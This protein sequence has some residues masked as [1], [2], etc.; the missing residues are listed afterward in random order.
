MSWPDP[1]ALRWSPTLR[2]PADDGTQLAV[3][4][5]GDNHPGP[6]VVFAHGWTFSSRQWHYQR[7]LA[8]RWRVV[9]FD[10]RGHGESE[11]GPRE[12]RT[13]DQVG[14]D[15]YSVMQATSAGRPVVPVGFSMGGMAVMAMA[16]QYP[17]AI[18]SWVKAAAFVSTSPGGQPENDYRLPAPLARIW[19]TRFAAG[20][21]QMRDDPVAAERVRRTGSRFSLAV[22]RWLNFGPKAERRLVAFTEAMS[23][24]CGAEVVGDFA[25][26][27]EAHDKLEALKA[28]AGIPTLVIVGSH[29]RLL[30]PSHSRALA[31]AIPDS[32]L[33][34]LKGAGHCTMLEQPDAVNAALSELLLSVADERVQAEAVPAPSSPA[35]SS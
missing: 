12:H 31:A 5:L 14:R 11:P 4:I 25:T 26:S 19:R 28:L 10:H 34:E 13:V 24:A 20:L 2:V 15:L 16:G 6:T 23:G 7:L 30:P 29:D 17:E 18:G 8:E 27:L 33:L 1:K 3:E 21:A 22:S 35:L 32:R 9:L